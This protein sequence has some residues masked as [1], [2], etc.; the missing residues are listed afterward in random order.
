MNSFIFRT[1]IPT[2]ITIH[3]TRQSTESFPHTWARCPPDLYEYIPYCN[4]IP[5]LW[6]NS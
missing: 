6:A 5:Q 3:T 2:I 1:T 4:T